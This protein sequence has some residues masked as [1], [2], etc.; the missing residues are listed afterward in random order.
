MT[1]IWGHVCLDA[2][3]S[4]HLCL[5]GLVLKEMLILVWLLIMVAL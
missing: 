2:S 1:T 4:H 5:V 3:K